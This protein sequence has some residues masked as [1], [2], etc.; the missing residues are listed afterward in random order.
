MVSETE[1]EFEDEDLAEVRAGS[2]ILPNLS[3]CIDRDDEPGYEIVFVK[4]RDE[5]SS[6]SPTK[7]VRNNMKLARI[8]EEEWNLARG[9]PCLGLGIDKHSPAEIKKQQARAKR[10]G[11]DI[12]KNMEEGEVDE[13]VINRVHEDIIKEY[14]KRVE[15]LNEGL[16]LDEMSEG[17]MIKPSS[18]TI[19]GCKELNTEQLLNFFKAYAP[20]KVDWVDDERCKLLWH[21]ESA[22]VRCILSCTHTAMDL[23]GLQA[24][25]QKLQKDRAK[26]KDK[27]KNSQNGET[28]NLDDEEEDMDFDIA[29]YWPFDGDLSE[30]RECVELYLLEDKKIRIMLRSSLECD[31]KIRGAQ[32]KSKYY[33]KYGNPNYGGMRGLLTKTFK[34]RYNYKKTREEIRKMGD[35]LG[36][37][38]KAQQSDYNPNQEKLD[39]SRA[40]AD[41]ELINSSVD[42]IPEAIPVDAFKL[43]AAPLYSDSESSAKESVFGRRLYSQS[44]TSDSEPEVRKSRSGSRRGSIKDRLGSLT[45]KK[46]IKTERNE[47]KRNELTG[48]TITLSQ[49]ASDKKK[50]EDKKRKRS[51][52]TMESDSDVSEVS[53]AQS[54]RNQGR[55]GSKYSESDSE[56]VKSYGSNVTS[57]SAASAASSRISTSSEASKYGKKRKP[58]DHYESDSSVTSGHSATSSRVSASSFNRS[59]SEYDSDTAHSDS[60]HS[61]VSYIGRRDSKRAYPSATICKLAVAKNLASRKRPLF[62]EKFDKRKLDHMNMTID[63]HVDRR[64][65]PSQSSGMETD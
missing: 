56:S 59:N 17:Q 48:L 37:T 20:D 49:N 42:E 57:S 16:N 40:K 41:V 47:K 61:E 51:Y 3:I 12:N 8:S 54:Y 52:E 45:P 36:V 28:I 11:L 63:V 43:P 35:R 55:R 33:V 10:F 9:I 64:R 15:E 23:A 53:S 2:A 27:K 13:D 32:S 4:I 39:S 22:A 6:D 14:S 21:E 38:L 62:G 58:I 26:P 31:Q 1:T 30:P 46:E 60:A 19:Y 18:V 44:E 34:R 50:S 24:K 29:S 25:A 65:K 7:V 5:G